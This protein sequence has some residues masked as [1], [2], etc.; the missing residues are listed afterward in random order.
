MKTVENIIIGFG[1][2][3]KTL[4]KF[5]A[6]KGEEVLVIETSTD[7]LEKLGYI[8]KVN[9]P[10]IMESLYQNQVYISEYNFC[11]YTDSKERFVSCFYF[12]DTEKIN[13]LKYFL[14]ENKDKKVDIVCGSLLLETLKRELPNQNYHTVDFAKFIKE[15]FNVYE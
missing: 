13:L 14:R 15:R 8:N 10:Q 5:L 2:G 3:G 6:Q 12:I 7:N 4:A 1:K 9:W 11:D